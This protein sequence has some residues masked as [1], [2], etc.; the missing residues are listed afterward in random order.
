MRGLDNAAKPSKRATKA[1]NLF[2]GA[3]QVLTRE[4]EGASRKLQ[5]G[6]GPVEVSHIF[7]F[8]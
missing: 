7:Y 3:V 1:L 4:H 5:E 6:L 2:T 8:T